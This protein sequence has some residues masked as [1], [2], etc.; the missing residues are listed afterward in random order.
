MNNAD[1]YFQIVNY[2]PVPTFWKDAERYSMGCN[3][4][5]LDMVDVENVDSLLEKRDIDLPW[6][7]NWESFERV[8]KQVLETGQTVSRLEQITSGVGDVVWSET[9]KHPIVQD[10]EVVGLVGFCNNV[11][12]DR[13]LQ[14]VERGRH[15]DRLNLQLADLVEKFINEAQRTKLSIVD[16]FLGLKQKNDRISRGQIKLSSREREIIYYLSIYKS[17]KEIARILS[18]VHDKEVS[19][20]AVQTAISDRL[21]FKFD[22]NTTS[23]LLER[24]AAHNLVPLRMPK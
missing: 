19:V 8:D 21:Y 4:K 14:E 13:N 15:I 20:R 17:P 9:I 11:T 6:A 5:F 16:Q 12:M 10:G 3:Q 22:V 2:S 23:Q 24:A 1:K 18:V 7:S